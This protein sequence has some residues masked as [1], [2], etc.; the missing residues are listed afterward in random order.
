MD[1]KKEL[2]QAYKEA[3]IEAGVYQ[4]KNRVNGKIF[5]A[6]TRNLKTLNGKQFELE[7]GTSTN[8]ILQKEWNEFGKEAFDFE[9][10]EVLI[11]KE[12]GYFNEKDALAKL[13]EKWMNEL[14]PYGDRGYNRMKK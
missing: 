14:Q 12:E 8:R 3:K 13:E 5:V 2:K 10:L 7:N 9:V 1:R 4:I 11:K 6:S